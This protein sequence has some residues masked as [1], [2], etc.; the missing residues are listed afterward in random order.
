MADLSEAV[1]LAQAQLRADGWRDGPFGLMPPGIPPFVLALRAVL[2]E[3]PLQAIVRAMRA[4]L[5]EPP[6]VTAARLLRAHLAWRACFIDTVP[7]IPSPPER[8]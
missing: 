5:A 4:E 7:L 3:D 8:N 2:T 1:W 6:S